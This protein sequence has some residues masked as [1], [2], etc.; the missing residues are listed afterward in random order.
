M[1]AGLVSGSELVSGVNEGL[2]SILASE[3]SFAIEFVWMYIHYKPLK[4]SLNPAFNSKR[5]YMPGQL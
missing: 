5:C 2:G 1:W 4:P 3:T